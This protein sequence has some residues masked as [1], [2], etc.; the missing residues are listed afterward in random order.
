M[1]SYIFNKLR[2]TFLT[3]FGF[4]SLVFLFAFSPY[5]SSKMMLD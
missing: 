3:L 1:I 2:N 4:V 5:D